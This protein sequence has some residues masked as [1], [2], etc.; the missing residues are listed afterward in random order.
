MSLS[1]IFP[2]LP[3]ENLSPCELHKVVLLLNPEQSFVNE[4]MMN[5]FFHM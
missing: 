2:L 4:V 1:R 3:H 5:G